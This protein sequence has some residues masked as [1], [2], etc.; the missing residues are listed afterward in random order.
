MSADNGIY[1]LQTKDGYRVAHLQAIDNIYWHP[2]CCENPHIVDD[3]L[4]EDM[5]YHEH[6]QIC[7]KVDPEYKI[8]EGV[9]NLTVIWMY[10]NRSVVY[11]D[12][13]SAMKK[14]DEIY[15][16]ITNDD[17]CGIVEY[18]IQFINGMEEMEFPA[19][20][21]LEKSDES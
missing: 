15:N 10:F 20:P 3:S 5:Y 12:R 13:E 1:I 8:R 6:C 4:G 19:A 9:A 17:F 11:P 14:A 2:D 21:V 16:E 7:G 18:G